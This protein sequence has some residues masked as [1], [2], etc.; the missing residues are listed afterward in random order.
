MA[1]RSKFKTWKSSSRQPMTA[2]T[3]SLLKLLHAGFNAIVMAAFFYQGWL[4][5][6]IKRGRA[7]LGIAPI[8]RISRH[9][10]LGP[11]LALLGPAGW[12]VGAGL[13]YMDRGGVF[14]YPPHFI[15]GLFIVN[16]I[17]MSYYISR[18]IR[19]ATPE[20]RKRHAWVGLF[21]LL[22]YPVQALLGLGIL[23]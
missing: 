10:R 4:G 16:L 6:S 7:R 3:S 17:I 8:H 2:E 20:I 22:L 15:T 18:K 13:V 5:L 14:L 19:V 9:R 11:W 23:L 21:I 12:L 1:P